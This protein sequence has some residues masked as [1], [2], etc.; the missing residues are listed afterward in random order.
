M[1]TLGLPFWLAGAYG[2]PEMVVAATELGAQG[3]QVGTL[4]ALSKDSGLRA[5]LR[6][7]LLSEIRSDTLKIYT[8]PAASPTS[9]P[10]KVAQLEGTISDGE[11]SENRNP[12]CDMG[13]L[14]VPF[15]NPNGRIDYRCAAEPTDMFIKKGGDVEELRGRECLCNGLTANVG[16]GQHRRNGYDEPPIVTLGSDMESVRALL[17]IYPEGFMAQEATQW[18]LQPSADLNS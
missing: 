7:Q 2:N 18:L 13:Y 3:V 10:I 9:F 8:D 4:F 16:L 1:V 12:L 14:R 17:R 5:D 15:L 11:V 6:E